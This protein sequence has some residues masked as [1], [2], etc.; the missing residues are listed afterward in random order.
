ML[1]SIKDTEQIE[2]YIMECFKTLHDIGI[3]T[4]IQFHPYNGQPT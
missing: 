4:E 3:S 1:E 2:K